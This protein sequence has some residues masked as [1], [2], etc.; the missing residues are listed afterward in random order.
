MTPFSHDRGRIVLL[1]FLATIVHFAFRLWERTGE[2]PWSESFLLAFARKEGG[3]DGYRHF[4]AVVYF[5]EVCDSHL[6]E[7]E[8][9]LESHLTRDGLSSI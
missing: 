7:G 5:K 8:N 9:L 1:N 6:T 2:N 3:S 4:E